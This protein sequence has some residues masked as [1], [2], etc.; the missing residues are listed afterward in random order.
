ML[1]EEDTR[2]EYEAMLLA[3]RVGWGGTPM[4]PLHICI[5]HTLWILMRTI[6]AACQK[7]KVGGV[8]ESNGELSA[9]E[10]QT[11]IRGAFSKAE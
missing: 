9:L 6:E 11:W 8:D 7:G 3:R 5:Q 10:I 4:Q 2:K 1:S